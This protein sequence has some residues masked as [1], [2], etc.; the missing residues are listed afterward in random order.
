MSR[1][2]RIIVHPPLASGG[3]QVT[4]GTE[5]LGVAYGLADVLEFLGHAGLDMNDLRLEDPG[6]VEWREGGPGVW[7]RSEDA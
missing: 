2:A 1:P 7:S 3:R 6:L 4:I 5:F